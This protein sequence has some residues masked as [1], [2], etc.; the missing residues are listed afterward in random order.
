MPTDARTYNSR[1]T[2]EALEKKFRDTFPSQSGAELV[3]DLYAS[4]V[5]IPTVD[6]SAAALGVTLE[7]ALQRAWDFS[8]GHTTVSNTTSTLVTTPG[9]WKVDLNILTESV[10]PDNATIFIDSGVTTK[11][12]WEVNTSGGGGTGR[13]GIGSNEFIVFLRS[14]DSLKATSSALEVDLDIWYR[15]VA[16]VS[17][18]LVNPFGFTS[19]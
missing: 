6:F 14:G 11:I 13:F 18:T 16:D 4:G 10:N 9:F 2:T 19:S 3:D 17:G 5:I 7:P 15:Q 1:I 8:T 12:I